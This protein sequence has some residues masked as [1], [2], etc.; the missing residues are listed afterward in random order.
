MKS[1]HPE[2]CFVKIPYQIIFPGALVLAA[3]SPSGEQVHVS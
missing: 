1:F 2:W 3:H